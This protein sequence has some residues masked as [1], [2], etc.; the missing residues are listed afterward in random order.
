M[1]TK[2]KTGGEDGARCLARPG[3]A[4]AGSVSRGCSDLYQRR[5]LEM[6]CQSRPNLKRR[7]MLGGLLQ[8][9]LDSKPVSSSHL[10]RALIKGFSFDF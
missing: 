10:K 3:R 8:K 9:C 1:R 5:G 6:D 7:R 2:E 4:R